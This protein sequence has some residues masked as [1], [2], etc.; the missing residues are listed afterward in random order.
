MTMRM[1]AFVPMLACVAGMQALPLHAADAPARLHDEIV[2]T[3]QT[4]MNAVG[5]GR[6]DVWQRS[7][8][9]DAVIVD[10]FGRVQHK[11]E[12]VEALRPF[13]AGFSGSIEVRN[14]QVQS[15]GD[16][17]VLQAEAY[18]REKVFG[19]PLVVRYLMLVTYVKQ[20]GAWKLVGYQ[21]VTLPTPP[22]KL[23]VPGL[24]LADY[25]GSYRY[26][27]GRAWTISAKDGA[28]G[29]VTHAGGPVNRLEPIARD[30]FMGSD[31]ERNL[32][33]FRR[34]AG[35]HVTELI[36]RRKFNDL[37]LVRETHG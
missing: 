35:G 18:E 30:V 2:A 37:H 13:P 19:Q 3:T 36:E 20:A 4:L 12:A 16:T 34:D 14:A 33:I 31:D 21:D 8:A 32:L 11:R 23:D 15:Y 1:S 17:A 24:R 9:E 27:P 22:P 29:Y 5:E 10:E 7:L 26:G 25:A 6:K 28:L